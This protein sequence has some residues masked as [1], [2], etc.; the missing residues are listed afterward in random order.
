MAGDSRGKDPS[1]VLALSFF[2]NN[3][4]CRLLISITLQTLHFNSQDVTF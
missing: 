2:S 1:R 4:A 3:E